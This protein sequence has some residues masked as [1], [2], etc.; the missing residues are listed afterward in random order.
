MSFSTLS[1]IL[2]R[3][4]YAEPGSPIAVFSCPQPGRLNAVFANTVITQNLIRR[5]DPTLIGVFDGTEE[6]WELRKQLRRFLL[7]ET[8]ALPINDLTN[9]A[10]GE[11]V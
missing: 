1:N 3:I 5:Q 11:P 4:K 2:L 10:L 6:E 9:A 7:P 8:E